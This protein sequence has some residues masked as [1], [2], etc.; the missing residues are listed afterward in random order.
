MW[1]ETKGGYTAECKFSEPDSE[2]ILGGRRVCVNAQLWIAR[3]GVGH[4][5][6]FQVTLDVS[7]GTEPSDV[8]WEVGIVKENFLRRVEDGEFDVLAH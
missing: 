4:N 1:L 3:G 7:A 5:C 2:L 8:E 6:A